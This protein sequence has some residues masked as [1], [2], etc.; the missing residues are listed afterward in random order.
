MGMPELQGKAMQEVQEGR[1]WSQA[2]M[3]PN[4]TPAR[5]VSGN[6]WRN[7]RYTYNSKD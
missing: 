4:C 6:I 3:G 2:N 1:A 7:S 5:S